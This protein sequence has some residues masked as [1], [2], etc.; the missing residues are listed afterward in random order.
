MDTPGQFCPVR[1]AAPA[2][3]ARLDL[4]EEC[5][6][7]SRHIVVGQTMRVAKTTQLREQQVDEVLTRATVDVER[8]SVGSIVDAIPETRQEGD[9]TIVPVVEEVLVLERRLV[10]K[11]EVR[12]KAHPD[13]GGAPPDGATPAAG[14]NRHP[15]GGERRH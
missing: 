4:P 5:V 13:H 12:D 10:L 8:V 11:E 3:A 9:V 1:K 2:E 6:D 15:L 14:R 7:V